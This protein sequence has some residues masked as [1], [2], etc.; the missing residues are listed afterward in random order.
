MNNDNL[1]RIDK[2]SIYKLSKYINMQLAFELDY[3]IRCEDE[4]TDYCELSD[5]M[6]EVYKEN[7]T[8]SIFE[9][10]KTLEDK[11]KKIYNKYNSYEESN[12]DNHI[13]PVSNLQQNHNNNNSI[14]PYILNQQSIEKFNKHI[15][16]T[17]LKQ[18]IEQFEKDKKRHESINHSNE[19]WV[20]SDI[21]L[22]QLNNDSSIRLWQDD[23]EIY[24]VT[25]LY[26][27]EN[28]NK[29]KISNDITK[30]IGE[31]VL[32][33]DNVTQTQENKNIKGELGY[34]P[35][36]I[37]QYKIPKV[38]DIFTPKITTKYLM[39]LD[40]LIF[41]NKFEYTEKLKLRITEN[42]T[43]K[44]DSNNKI[45]DFLQKMVSTQEKYKYII[46]WL[47]AFFQSLDKSKFAL[48]LVGDDEIS[49]DI[50]YNEIIKPIFGSKYCSTINTQNIKDQS[51]YKLI[52]EHI[53]YNI[54]N[55]SYETYKENKQVF[56]NLLIKDNIEY[57]KTSK[58][59]KE[60]IYIHGNTLITIPTVEDS[61]I[62][63]I[64]GR[65][66]IVCMNSLETIKE[67]MNYEDPLSLYA[68]INDDLM[69]FA[70][71]LAS[72]KVDDELLN[73]PIKIEIKQ[74]SNI[75]T[76]NE[77]IEEFIKAIK[78]ADPKIEYFDPIKKNEELYKGLS[79][80]FDKN[81]FIGK[82]LLNYF[83]LIY[84]KNDYKNNTQFLADLKEKDEMFKQEITILKVIN[85]EG[86]EE[87]V[88]KGI[89]SFKEIKYDKLYKITDYT[90]PI[91]IDI[92]KGY[93]IKN[94][95]GNARFK[96]NHEDLEYAKIVH[97][98][99]DEQIKKDK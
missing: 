54:D 78:G 12:M 17:N 61:F 89:S 28:G 48:T 21:L 22:K 46:N 6:D 5:Q 38:L 10:Q 91:N 30:D 34:A 11:K 33:I 44:V 73:S 62:K 1:I 43:S 47:A 27:I 63:E 55:I 72:Y 77:K 97:K 71:Y 29:H 45:I 60:S 95:E 42:N 36:Y 8:K 81:C 51:I 59:P 15:E 82:D 50:F 3:N 40:N 57:Q 23:K 24:F 68:D 56:R 88:F 39:V 31:D 66:S 20:K 65:C 94:R 92:S 69:N 14:Q 32:I 64:K 18:L 79:F 86:I 58:S 80:S 26:N 7:G 96:Y 41:K 75:R 74:E 99:Y 2:S 4:Y 85:K 98:K 87:E 93:I 83:T 76:I 35:R 52:D 70:T 37:L 16:D 19:I 25:K 53:F 49:I 84:G 9:F 67:D 90:L 13:V